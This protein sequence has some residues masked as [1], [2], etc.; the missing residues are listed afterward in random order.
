VSRI[1]VP[2]LPRWLRWTAVA[3]VVAVIVY[4]SV[5]T[6]PPGPPTKVEFWDKHL[7]FAAYAAFVL[8]LTYATVEYS[9]QNL[10]RA[11]AIAGLAVAF[12]A[13]IEVIQSFL[14]Y[15]YFGWWDLLANVL[16]SALGLTWFL[17]ES[18]I[19]YVGAGRYITPFFTE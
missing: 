6:V 9:D 14:E 17:V 13:L 12:G 1:P 5:L 16:G 19:R 4:Y 7:H 10:F 8:T 11:L 18:R 3:S 15:R 2:L